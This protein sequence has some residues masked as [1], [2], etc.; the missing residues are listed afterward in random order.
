MGGVFE[1]RQI[2]PR[3][4]DAK[5][6]MTNSTVTGQCTHIIS[7]LG[8]LCGFIVLLRNHLDCIEWS[9][10]TDDGLASLDHISILQANSRSASVL[11]N[12][13]IH[14]SIKLK[15]STKLF[16]T[17]LKS[18]AKLGCS[19]N[20]NAKGCRFFEKAFKNVQNMRRHGSLGGETAKD[21]HAIDK[22]ANKRDGDDFINSLGKIVKR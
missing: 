21:A 11:N 20:G 5:E 8:E 18:F 17:S 10:I 16:E 2:E 7:P 4:V 22:V 13:F 3:S 6:Q 9:G 15:F 19:T 14:M 1:V 12:D